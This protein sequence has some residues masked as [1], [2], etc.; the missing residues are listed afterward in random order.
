MN[1]ITLSILALLLVATTATYAQD[2]TANRPSPPAEVIG[3]VDGTKIT[4]NYSQPSV[5]DR[6][7]YGNLVPY[8]EVWRTGANE[9]T[10]F[11]VNTDVEIE[12]KTLPAGKYA[13]FTIPRENEDWTVVFNKTAEQWGAFDYEES[14]DALRVDVAP[15]DA[16]ETVEKLTFEVGDSGEVTLM[17]ANKAVS[18]DVAGTAQASN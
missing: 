9:A 7:I 6:A 15:Q 12:G 8:D 11:A 16:E 5:K 2:D 13:L 10:T 4:I 1:K 14:Q 17:W 3:T 18:F